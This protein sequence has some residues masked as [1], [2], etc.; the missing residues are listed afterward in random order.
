MLYDVARRQRLEANILHEIDA[1]VARI[2]DELRG[3]LSFPIARKAGETGVL[4]V[5]LITMSHGWFVS[6]GGYYGERDTAW[7][8]KLDMPS[9]TACLRFLTTGT[10]AD[11]GFSVQAAIARA[12][13]FKRD[14]E[15]TQW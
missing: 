3:Y 2:P 12:R 7:L 14:C 10:N 9:L 15:A 4:E 5:A 13:D 11:L 8:S 1:L 6:A